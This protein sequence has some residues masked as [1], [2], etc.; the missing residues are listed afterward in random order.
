M[1]AMYDLPALAR[2]EA[3]ASSGPARRADLIQAELA[4]VDVDFRRA[5]GDRTDDWLPW[6][7]TA[8]QRALDN[9]KSAFREAA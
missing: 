6:Q 1:T 3:V 2:D 4:R 8:Y 5:Y 9:V 7:W